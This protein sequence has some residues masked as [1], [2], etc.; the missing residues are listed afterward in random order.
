MSDA[1]S[2]VTRKSGRTSVK[3]RIEAF[4]LSNIGRVVEREEIIEAA[5]DP[6]T[7]RE[8][9]NW[10]QRLSE[11]R[12][13]DG[14]TIL[15][16]RDRKTL[17]PGQYLMPA[18]EKRPTAGRRVQIDPDTWKEVLRRAGYACEWR[19]GDYTCGLKDGEI[20][21]VGG[22]KVKLTP[23]HK[24]PHSLDPDIDPSDPSQWQALCG[25]HQVMKKNYWNHQT[26]K[27]NVYAIVQGAAETEKRRV[28][29]FLKSYFEE[30]SE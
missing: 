7:G 9:E 30:D 13:D 17:K 6:E 16:W 28:Y 21:P 10:H 27:L 14:Y 4:F 29:E 26:G 11:L 19:D 20:D 22:G 1:S 8:P 3:R 25:R 18:D 15:S 2:R 5:R 12:T 24:Q 23:D